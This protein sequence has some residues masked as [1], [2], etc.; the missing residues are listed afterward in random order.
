MLFEGVELYGSAGVDICSDCLLVMMHATMQ[1]RAN[2]TDPGANTKLSKAVR[3]ASSRIHCT[4]G[5]GT[6]RQSL[7]RTSLI[8]D[9]RIYKEDISETGGRIAQPV[10]MLQSI[11]N[12]ACGSN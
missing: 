9:F 5:R 3:S 1:R 2:E 7:T 6:S 8:C 4:G 11:L 12:V 10:V